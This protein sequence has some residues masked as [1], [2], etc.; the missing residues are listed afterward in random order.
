[1]ITFIPAE[2]H[3]SIVCVCSESMSVL[4][5]FTSKNVLILLPLNP[6]EVFTYSTLRNT[7]CMHLPTQQVYAFFFFVAAMKQTPSLQKISSKHIQEKRELDK[8]VQWFIQ[9][10]KKAHLVSTK[11]TKQINSRLGRLT[12]TAED[13]PPFLLLKKKPQLP[14]TN[15]RCSC[16]LCCSTCPFHITGRL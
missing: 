4:R 7:F 2:Y 16:S 11:Q 3:V 10:R 1:M 9:S 15:E 6:W 12:A 14:P 8:Q 5:I 13:F